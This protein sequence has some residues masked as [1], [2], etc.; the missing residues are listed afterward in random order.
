MKIIQGGYKMSKLR[1]SGTSL[2]LA[3]KTIRRSKPGETVQ[4]NLFR[5]GDI[6]W[7][8]HGWP[9]E[10]HRGKSRCLTLIHIALACRWCWMRIIPAEHVPYDEGRPKHYT[11]KHYTRSIFGTMV[12]M[13]VS[14]WQ[15]VSA[16]VWMLWRK[17]SKH[18]AGSQ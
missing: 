15:E 13:P 3:F 6:R 17:Q 10:W 14:R 16:C 9:L 8:G 5:G 2:C 7:R 18:A 4:S 12:T 11:V 1:W